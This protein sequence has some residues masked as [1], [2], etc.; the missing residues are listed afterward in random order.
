MPDYLLAYNLSPKPSAFSNK[1]DPRVEVETE[2]FLRYLANAHHVIAETKRLCSKDQLHD[3]RLEVYPDPTTPSSI[4]QE[5]GHHPTPPPFH[6]YLASLVPTDP[7]IFV[8]HNVN[9]IIF[10]AMNINNQLFDLQSLRTLNTPHQ[11]SR[12]GNI[13][14]MQTIAQHLKVVEIHQKND[15]VHLDERSGLIAMNPYTF[16]A[17]AAIKDYIS[18]CIRN[19]STTITDSLKASEY[20]F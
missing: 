19:A 4:S 17:H 16:T 20:A 5:I 12:R 18:T 11:H 13:H 15:F 10:W 8:M 9:A 3:N 14:A 7:Q 2:D 6:M 1:L